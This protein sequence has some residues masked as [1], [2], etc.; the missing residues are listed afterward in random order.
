MR[1][2]NGNAGKDGEMDE[3]QRDEEADVRDAGCH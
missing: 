2:I 3:G 1:C